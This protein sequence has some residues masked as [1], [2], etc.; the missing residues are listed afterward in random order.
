ELEDIH[1]IV[2]NMF[3]ELIE[4]TVDAHCS[5]KDVP[6]DWDLQGIVDYCN[7]TFLREGQL[8]KDELWGKEKEE[9]VQLMKDLVRRLYEQRREQLGEELMREFEKV[10][11]L[12]AVDSKWMDH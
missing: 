9:M 3:D 4:R 7:G 5:D 12:R 6:E 1:E 2:L 10:V 8:T 11:V